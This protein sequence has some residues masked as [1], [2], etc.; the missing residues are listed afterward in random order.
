MKRKVIEEQ[1]ESHVDIEETKY[2]CVES[3]RENVKLAN[4]RKITAWQHYKY[5]LAY[6]LIRI[7]DEEMKSRLIHGSKTIALLFSYME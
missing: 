2:L 1:E 4:G 7:D 3:E 5:Q 6:N